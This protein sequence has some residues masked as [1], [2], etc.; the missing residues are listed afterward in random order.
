MPARLDERVFGLTPPLFRGTAL[1]RGCLRRL[2]RAL[3]VGFGL[4]ER[5]AGVLHRLGGPVLFARRPGDLELFPFGRVLRV[6]DRA[7][8]GGDRFARADEDPRVTLRRRM[9][10]ARD[11]RRGT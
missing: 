1:T 7:V 5:F 6:S 3:E 4:G 8:G 11:R 9:G 10:A 2:L